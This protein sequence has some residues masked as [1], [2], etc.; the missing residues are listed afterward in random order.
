MNLRALVYALLR[1][2]VATAATPSRSSLGRRDSTAAEDALIAKSC[3]PPTGTA[4]SSVAS[5]PSEVGSEQAAEEVVLVV[6]DEPLVAMLLGR[7]AQSCAAGRSGG[8][9]RRHSR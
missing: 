2:L 4:T 3:C 9:G 8:H 5:S 7:L 6:D 1:A